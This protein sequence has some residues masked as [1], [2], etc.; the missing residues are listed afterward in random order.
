MKQPAHF[1]MA[2]G[3]T[4]GHVTPA[5]AVARALKEHGHSP[6]FIGTR[7][8]LEAK[9]VPAAGFPIEWIE[10]ARIKGAGLSG[11]MAVC[12]RMP[13]AVRTVLAYF[14]RYRPAAVFSM[15]GFVAGPVVAAAAMK[16]LP[17]VVMEP[18]AM[19]G[20]TNR[21]VGR[22]V[23]KALL[24]FPEAE[25]Y[26]PKGRTEISGV[27]VRREFFELPPKAPGSGPLTVLVTGGSQGSRTL[28]RAARESWPLFRK[29]GLAVRILHQTGTSEFEAIEREFREAG[30]DGEVM[31]FITD[32]PRAFGEADVI[33]SRSGAGTV[34]EIAAAG[35]AAILVPYPYAAD[36][37]QLKN[38]E[39]FA[40]AGA[41]RL[42]LDREMSG[43]RLVAEVGE[44]ADKLREMGERARRFAKPDA[45]R[46]AAEVLE[47]FAV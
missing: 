5:L 31:P 27:P 46:R 10:S 6:I 15:G 9:L 38:A 35:K 39:A 47:S 18:N 44:S 24:S 23:A 19:P 17:L 21:Y 26:F 8:G 42:V 45:A 13:A 12:R 28:N 25:R 4:G 32:M 37:H 14:E 33:V 16:R 20:A 34:A 40:K 22:F 2:G 36:Q 43:A 41:A 1:I 3:G 7:D 29:A 11:I 30:M